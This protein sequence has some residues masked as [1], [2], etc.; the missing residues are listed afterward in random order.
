ML[1]TILWV[2]PSWY[3]DKV[4]R[5]ISLSP[6]MA[7]N[8]GI[9]GEG[10]SEER[11]PFSF[12]VAPL[13]LYT[14]SGKRHWRISFLYLH[15]KTTSPISKIAY[16]FFFR[17]LSCPTLNYTCMGWLYCSSVLDSLL[18]S[19][20]SVWWAVAVQF[21]DHTIVWAVLFPRRRGPASIH[22]V[23]PILSS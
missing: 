13:A 21:Q 23:G 6:T 17:N 5:A 12:L 16:V 3:S 4:H 19:H 8:I 20:V 15:I 22:Q 7:N 11:Y 9:S 10:G 14:V 2:I 18:R 1:Y